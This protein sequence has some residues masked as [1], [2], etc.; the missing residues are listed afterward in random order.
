MKNNIFR[1]FAL[2]LCI[3]LTLSLMV[4]CSSEKELKTTNTRKYQQITNGSSAQTGMICENEKFELHWD[5]TKKI[6]SFVDK[7]TGRKYSPV[8]EEA[9]IADYDENGILKKN[10]P[11]IES[12]LTVYYY[13]QTTLNE[14]FI[15]AAIEAVQEGAVYTQNI[16]NGLRVYYD[17]IGYEIIVPIEY[18]IYNDHFDVT[19]ITSY[20]G[21]NGENFVTGVAIAPYF[22]SL[23]ND[24]PDSYFFLPDGSGTLIGCNT[25]DLI[26]TQG[27]MN[28]YG[29]DP[30]IQSYHLESYRKQ[31]HLPVFGVKKADSAMLGIITSGAEQAEIS[32]NIGS[33]NIGYS[34]IYPFFRIRGY[35][36]IHAPNNFAAAVVELPVFAEYINTSPL[37]VS[38]YILDGA[39][40]DYNGM[41]KTYR[42][43]LIGSGELNKSDATMPSVSL[44]LLGGVETKT[45]NFGIPKTT[46]YPLT[47]IA[48]AE[49]MVIYFSK[50]LDNDVL[51]DL[52]GFGQSG[53]D[54]GKLA[55]G[56]KVASKLG[57]A[58]TVRKFTEL[59]K[60]KNIPVFMDFDL[61]SFNKSGAGFSLI[62]DAAA[63]PNKQNS[64]DVRK[65]YVTRKET[66]ARYNLLSRD[67]LGEATKKAVDV[68]NY[69]G[70]T[71][72]SLSSLSNTAYSDYNVQDAWVRG[73]MSEQ[74]SELFKIYNNDSKILSVAA[75]SYAI[76]NSSYIID[77]P[78]NSSSLDVSIEDVPFYSL[79]FRGYVPMSSESVNLAA[80]ERVALLRAIESGLGLTYTVYKNFDNTLFT[81]D[82]S[83]L[84]G[85]VYDGNKEQIVKTGKEIKKLL[86][87]IGNSTIS[88]HTIL[89]NGLRI[90]TFSNGVKAAINETDKDIV[91]NGKN[92]LSMD[93]IVIEE[94]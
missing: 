60:D 47:T 16:E 68:S 25:I 89:D 58:K 44:K 72:V 5:D 27:S 45:Y 82:Q 67:M 26:G 3:I 24:T 30:T 7:A 17:F 78:T 56:F 93:Y 8:P 42:Q 87:K 36:L 38:Y 31:M 46:L 4:G 39:D 71:G 2:I 53:L 11:Q 90:T 15:T 9:M 34:G 6:V 92:V 85:S 29:I 57:N 84:Y 50:E 76:G 43:Y 32:W 94:G 49:E 81:I 61:V 22:C 52:V 33:S 75:N 79:V 66:D 20:I 77:V 88:D 74:V 1:V 19:V 41:A 23:K 65:D 28:I 69:Y 14:K 13:D 12:A 62:N 18:K 83:A 73:G 48:D 35:N 63:F 54:F 10:N 40:A 51:L 37:S 21:D 80:N 55:G 59:C 64:Y 70:L 91:L 86:D